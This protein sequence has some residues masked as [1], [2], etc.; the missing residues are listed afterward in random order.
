MEIQ[1]KDNKIFA[2][3]L[4]K[5]LV[6]MPEEEV[7]Q[8]FICKLVDDYGYSLKQMDQEVKLTKSQRGT[9]RASADLVVWLNE[10]DKK[11]KKSAFLV[12]ELKAKSLK[13]K[14]EDC[15]Q[16]YNY[17][18]WSRAKLFAISNRPVASIQ[19]RIAFKSRFNSFNHC[20]NSCIPVGSLL[21]CR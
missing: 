10:A 4:N 1:I 9:G 11:A 20:N 16:G 19:N 14:V 12:V 3:L 18:T 2:P 6:Y 17:A 15:Y 5:W 21:N 8:E 7:R 13:L